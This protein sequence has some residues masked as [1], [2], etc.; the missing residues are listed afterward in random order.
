M[1]RLP[2]EKFR[3]WHAKYLP[4]DDQTAEDRYRELGG[5]V[6]VKPA[7]KREK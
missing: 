5:K 7:G 6:P 4:A 1:V 3:A 2:F